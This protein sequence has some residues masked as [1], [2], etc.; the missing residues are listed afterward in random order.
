MG[1]RIGILVGVASAAAFFLIQK[2]LLGWPY[3][4]G[5]IATFAVLVVSTTLA[6]FLNKTAAGKLRSD[7][8]IMSNIEVERGMKATIDGLETAETP[9]N[10]L[11]DIKVGG[12][13]EFT[14]KNTRL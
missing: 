5:I 9:A 11:S 7:A 12:D 8:E 4:W 2:Y 3:P 14:I 1:I 10:L 6:A 13:A